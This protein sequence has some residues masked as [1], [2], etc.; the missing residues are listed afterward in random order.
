M[1]HLPL[2]EMRFWS[3]WIDAAK[4]RGT[5]LKDIEGMVQMF[6]DQE[7]KHFPYGSTTR[8]CVLATAWGF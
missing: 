5:S 7:Y 6:L 4:R 3:Q 1:K 2:K 8:S